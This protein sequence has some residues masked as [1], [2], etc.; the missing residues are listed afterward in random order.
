[1]ILLTKTTYALAD[2]KVPAYIILAG[3][4]ILNALTSILH[5]Y[6]QATPCQQQNPMQTHTRV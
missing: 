2:S 4:T 1:M 5:T 6:D 3:V